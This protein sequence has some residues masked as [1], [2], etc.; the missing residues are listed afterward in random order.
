MGQ[1]VPVPLKKK[2]KAKKNICMVTAPTNE[3]L[4]LDRTP[5]PP[6]NHH[7]PKVWN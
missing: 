2:G 6:D 4:K 5:P 1:T 3:L 7:P